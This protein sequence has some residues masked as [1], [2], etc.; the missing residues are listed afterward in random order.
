MKISLQKLEEAYKEAIKAFAENE[1]LEMYCVPVY[2]DKDYLKIF[3]RPFS[4][5]E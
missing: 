1:Q 5:Y 4:W 3:R 2:K